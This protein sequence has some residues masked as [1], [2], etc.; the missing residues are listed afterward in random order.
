M[1]N[2]LFINFVKI[3]FE[4][5]I[6]GIVTIEFDLVVHFIIFIRKFTYLTTSKSLQAKLCFTT[7]LY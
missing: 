7:I 1:K 2:L 5:L 4:N 3:N 6:F